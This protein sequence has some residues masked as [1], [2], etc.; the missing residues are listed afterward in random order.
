MQA[1]PS[2]LHNASP[3]RRPACDHQLR[4]GARGTYIVQ[5]AGPVEDAWKVAVTAA[6]GELLEYIPDFAFK[7]RMTPAQALVVRRLAQVRWV[8]FFHPAYKL[9]PR[10]RRGGQRLYTIRLER[11]TDEGAAADAV[12]AAGGSV[13]SREGGLLTVSADES[14]IEAL[15]QI[16]DVAWIEDYQIREKHNEYA[17]QII[18]APTA[19]AT[20]VGYDGSTQTVAVA[21]TGLGGGTAATAHSDLPASRITNISN[22]PGDAGGCSSHHQRWRQGRGQRPRHARFGI[23]PRRWNASG[24]GKGPGSRGTPRLSGGRGT[25]RRSQASAKPCTGP[26]TPTIS[27]ASRLTSALSFSARRRSPRPLQLLGQREHRCLHHRQPEPRRLCP[28]PP[29]R[30]RHL[31][32]RQR[33]G[34]RGREWRSRLALACHPSKH[35]KNVLTVGASEN[36]RASDWALRH[37]PRLHDVWARGAKNGIFTYGSALAG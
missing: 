5:F 32:R 7:V 37:L 18:G 19:W 29:G 4:P 2:S 23:R 1:A 9:S 3:A 13:A 11:G 24:K 36:D 14:R 22:W 26:R 31:F 16:L 30:H 34:G 6:G 20:G 33:R 28:E 8:G 21:D 27:P 17:G 25:G 15:A 35:E 12:A 10:L